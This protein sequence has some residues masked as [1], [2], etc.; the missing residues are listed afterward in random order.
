MSKRRRILNFCALLCL[1]ALQC[2][3]LAQPVGESGDKSV[4]IVR[5]GTPPVIDGVL[6]EGV[7]VQAGVLEDFHEVSPNEYDEPSQETLV[8]LLY[9]E[10]RLYIG[11]QLLDDR[12]GRHSRPR[13]VRGDGDSVQDAVIRPG[14]G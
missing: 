10:T 6:D 11:A 2:A 1:P 14:R 12:A 8:Y 9:D 13:L 4:R 7:W 3:A 5:T